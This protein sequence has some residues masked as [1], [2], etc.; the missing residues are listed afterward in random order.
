MEDQFR[1]RDVSHINKFDGT[2]YQQWRK[3]I[4]IQLRLKR[5]FELVK[6]T[7]NRTT[8]TRTSTFN[9]KLSIG[10]RTK[11]PGGLW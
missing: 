1:A 7:K 8:Y 3:A 9:N 10:R 6:V 2:D 11:T 4:S 5:I